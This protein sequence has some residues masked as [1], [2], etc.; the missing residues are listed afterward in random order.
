MGKNDAVK[1]DALRE[2][3]NTTKQSLAFLK[4]DA[5][6]NCLELYK[7]GF[8]KDIDLANYEKQAIAYQVEK[9]AKAKA[10]AELLE[11]A[12]NEAFKTFSDMWDKRYSRSCV[13]TAYNLLIND[14]Q[15]GVIECETVEAISSWLHHY[16][17]G[18][19]SEI[20]KDATFMS[21]LKLVKG[22]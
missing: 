3:A 16:L 11:K 7:V 21:Y 5:D 20:I 4:T 8:H 6:G 15:I 14:Y 1:F 9:E 2:H 18:E 17:I 19:T 22:E 13:I 10:N 12:R